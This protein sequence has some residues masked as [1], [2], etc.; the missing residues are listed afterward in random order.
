MNKPRANEGLVGG[1]VECHEF[2]TL[3]HRTRMRVSR[4]RDTRPLSVKLREIM[5]YCAEKEMEIRCNQAGFNLL[6]V[7]LSLT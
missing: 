3:V 5:L 6:L 2:E 1:E 4:I 7:S